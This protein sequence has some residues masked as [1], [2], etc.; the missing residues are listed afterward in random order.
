MIHER[1]SS[2]DLRMQLEDALS[3]EERNMEDMEA[4][5]MHL[6]VGKIIIIIMIIDIYFPRNVLANCNFLFQLYA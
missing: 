1:Q 5:Q 4:I 6:Q 2:E 3:R